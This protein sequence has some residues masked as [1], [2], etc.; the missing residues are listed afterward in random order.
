VVGNIKIITGAEGKV[1]EREGIKLHSE[2]LHNF[3]LPAYWGEKNSN[4]VVMDDHLSCKAERRISNSF[5]MKTRRKKT[6]WKT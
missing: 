5:F 2:E 3:Y 6:T 4:W 1:C